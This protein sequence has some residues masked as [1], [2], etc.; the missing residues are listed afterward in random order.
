MRLPVATFVVVLATAVGACKRSGGSAAGDAGQG[1][2]QAEPSPT[3]IVTEAGPFTAVRILPDSGPPASGIPVPA[4]K[5]EEAV[6]PLHLAP[7]AGPTGVIEG[8]ITATGDPPPKQEIEIPFECGEAYATY[9]KAYREGT[10]RTLADVMVA[11]T[12]YEGYVPSPGDEQAVKIHG[13]A[14]DRRTVV[15]TYGQHLDVK[16]TDTKQTFLPVLDGAWAPAQ[17]AAVP[18]GDGVKL[19]PTEVG[20][21]VLRDD[22]GHKWMH[23]DVFALRYATH[24]VTG[25]DGHYRIAG[26]PPGKV[27]VSTYLPPIDAQLHPDVGIAKSA[28]ERE[29][30]VKAGE[31]VKAD[32]S[33]A[34]KAPKRPPP[35]PKGEPERPII[36]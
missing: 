29:I 30:E 20:H 5:V 33:I 11:V 9:G 15:V 36:K 16:N 12:G 21:Y 32:F 22:A 10:G 1:G 7:Y 8:V 14:F 2:G 28:E 17:M 34:Y 3:A 13:C 4:S 24:A 6:N 18:R 31:T 26:I 19:Y 23:A 27:K 35:K 25:L